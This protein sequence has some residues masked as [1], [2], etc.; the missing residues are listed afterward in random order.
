MN[1]RL[2]TGDDFLIYLYDK[3]ALTARLIKLMDA[4]KLQLSPEELRLVQDGSWILTKNSI[5]ERMVQ[6]LADLSGEC[7]A[8]WEGRE[9]E[10][11]GRPRIP[12]SEPKVSRGENYKGLP[13]V[14]LDYPRLFGREDVLA[15]RTMFWWG[16]AFSVTLHLKGAYQRIFLPVILDRWEALSAAGFHV[17]VSE[18]EWMHE[19]VPENYRPMSGVPDPAGMGH[20]DAGDVLGADGTH[21]LADRPFLKLS[22]ACGLDKWE[23]APEWLLAHFRLLADVLE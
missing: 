20:G 1:T 3:R 5:L 4:A 11:R 17:G 6:L 10:G 21:G 19:H 7:R 16:H 18:D 8:L 9:Q 22:V 14:I 15:I 12:H 13:Y 23:T 2:S